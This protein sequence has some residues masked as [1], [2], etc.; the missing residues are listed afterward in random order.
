MWKE[1]LL[2][3]NF[4]WVILRSVQLFVKAVAFFSTGR[5]IDIISNK[6][7]VTQGAFTLLALS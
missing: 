3:S 6:S 2:P 4:M 1:Y 7:L 5:L